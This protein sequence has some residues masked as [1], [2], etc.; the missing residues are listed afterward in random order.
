[1]T[2]RHRDLRSGT[3]VWTASRMPAFPT[4]KATRDF[5]TDVL[6]I[7]AGISGAMLADALSEAGLKICV[8]DRRGA[9]R[10]ST[11]ASTALLQYEL[12]TPL[13]QM[14]KKIGEPKAHRIW[15]RSK[16]AVCALQERTLRLGIRAELA[17][18]DTL[19]LAG[20][21]LG[22]DGLQKEGEARRR[23]GFECQWLSAKEVREQ[24]GIERRAALRSFG[25]AVAEPRKLAAGFLRAAIARGAKLY[26]PL[27]VLDVQP[28]ARGVKA[29]LSNGLTITARHLIFA[30][31]YELPK[32]IPAKSHKIISTWA[33]ATK[34]QPRH[35]WPTAAMLWEASDPYLYL[36]STSDGRVICGGADEDFLDEQRRDAKLPAKT[37]LLERKLAALFPALDARA[38]FAWTG[39]FGASPLGTPT[40]GAVPHL[41]H[42][43]A[44]LGYGGNGITFSMM[45]AQILTGLITGE[46]DADAELF[47]FGQP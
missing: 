20:N 24:Y 27:E 40:I 34:P 44:V 45:A 33:M 23:L 15:R 30:T 22:A 42:C 13:L 5:K 28:Q 10:G 31:G 18:R 35:L 8:V 19:Y 32:Q 29:L 38:S 26:A 11:A 9:V 47:G 7:G 36:R 43:Y 41:P 37:K 4:E 14:R 16:L 25:N 12:D 1:M 2:T 6:V 46:G 21:V 39:C 3:A 17:P